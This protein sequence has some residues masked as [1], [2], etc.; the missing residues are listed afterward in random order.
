MPPLETSG[1]TTSFFEFWP[2]WLMYFPVAIQWILLSIRYHSLSL[3]LIANPAVPLSGMVG[4][5]KS[6]V[7][8]AAGATARQWILPWCL[9]DMGDE[10]LQ[11]QCLM[12]QKKIEEAGLSFPL[13]AKPNMG[14]RGVGVRLLSNKQELEAYLSEFP[15][16]G[17]VQFQHL[18]QW[19]AEAGVFYVRHPDDETGEVTSLTLKY[20][21]YVVGDGKRSLGELVADEPRAGGLLHLYKERH[22][23]Q[24]DHIIPEAEPFRLVFAASHSRGAI[25]RDAKELMDIKLTQSLDTIF[26]DIPGFYYGRLDVKFKDTQSLSQGKNFEI[27]EINGASSES[28]NIWDRNAGFWTAI[29][30]LLQQYNTLFKLGHAN[31]KRGHKPPGLMA[32]YKAWRYENNLVKHYPYND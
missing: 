27:I 17:C 7:F 23:D 30:T 11:Q 8:E 5:A 29:K 25:F 9:F 16:G 15:V 21:P 32:L 22:A 26:K 14:C 13:V 31:R 4:V 2:A 19:D 24:W 18:S 20:M 3:P 28:I 12:A 6:A 10:E 1:R